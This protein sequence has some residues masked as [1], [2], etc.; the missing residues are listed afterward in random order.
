[1]KEDIVIAGAVRTAIGR[2]GGTL[3]GTP[4]VELG[5]TAIKASLERSGI[6]VDYVDEVIMGNVLQ[7]GEGQGT[8]RQASVAAGLPVE[9]PAMNV[10]NICG[11]GLKAVNLAAAMVA[12]ADADVVVAGGMENMSAAGYLAKMARWGGR[13]GNQELVDTML[14]DALED[15]F[16]RYH[17]GVTAENVAEKWGISRGEQ[18]R[19]AAAS[20]N[21]AE[22]AR[23][24]G[25][26]R[27]EIIPVTVKG[28][29]GVGET[30]FAED[31]YPRHGVTVES[32]AALKPAFRE[33]GT[34][35]AGNSSGINDGAAAVVVLR[36]GKAQDLGVTPI[37]RIVAY[38]SAGVDPAYMGTGPIYSTRK[39][40]ERAGLHLRDIDLIEANEAFAAQSLC[41]SR[42]LGWDPEIVNVNGGAI[43]L[44]HPVGA[45]GARILVTLIYE[46]RKRKVRYG[47]ATLCVGGGMGVTT[48]IERM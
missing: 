21:K 41:V 25:R 7:A 43:A 2:F 29:G 42:E 17:M 6:A 44:G 35:T 28:R 40:L 11:S 26:F 37:A 10:N 32:L 15:A 34:V 8:G 19:F 47:L 23:A 13:M 38:A 45:S 33:G 27:E 30:D 24:S 36:A 18:D 46:M 48:I 31:E 14:R 1:M 16:G 39:A 9:V 3:A 5:S 12:S 22:R 20:Q 4:V